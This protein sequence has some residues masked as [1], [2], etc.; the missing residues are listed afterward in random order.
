MTHERAA[1]E[2]VRRY[3]NMIEARDPF[4]QGY[5][6]ALSAKEQEVRELVEALRSVVAESGR[7][8]LWANVNDERAAREELALSTDEECYKVSVT[9]ANE[10][11]SKHPQP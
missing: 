10:L 6:S 3:P 11:L 1:A 9:K 4:I 2:A 8:A 5:L 7:M